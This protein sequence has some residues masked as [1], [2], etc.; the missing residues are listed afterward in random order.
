VFKDEAFGNDQAQMKVPMMTGFD[1]I[2]AI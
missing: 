2:G 1:K